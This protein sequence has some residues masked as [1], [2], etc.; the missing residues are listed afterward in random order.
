MRIIA[1]IYRLIYNRSFYHCQLAFYT[2]CVCGTGKNTATEPTSYIWKQ[3][4]ANR[5]SVE[6][7]GGLV[8]YLNTHKDFW[9]KNIT[10][11]RMFCDSCGGQNKNW[12]VIHALAHWLAIH[13]RQIE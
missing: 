10:K 12:R 11:V 8:H 9:A 1:S 6:I 3:T 4:Q 5:G 2:F 13:D 7:V